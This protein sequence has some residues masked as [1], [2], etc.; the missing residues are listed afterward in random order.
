MNTINQI[1]TLINAIVSA[2]IKLVEGTTTITDSVANLAPTIATE[3]DIINESL[4]ADQ[5]KRR[6]ELAT[7][8]E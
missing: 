1:F 7:E 5:A 8:P 2:A 4:Q 3:V 6:L